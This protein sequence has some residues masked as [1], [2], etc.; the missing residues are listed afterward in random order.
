M[1]FVWHLHV[2]ECSLPLLNVD[3]WR[4]F[5]CT[6]QV[7]GYHLQAV[8]ELSEGLD[9]LDNCNIDNEE[10]ISKGEDS[11]H[12]ESTRFAGHVSKFY[13]MGTVVV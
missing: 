9:D 4:V 7:M 8:D 2:D 12:L 11:S 3:V 5:L 1:H 6:E 13:S 10:L